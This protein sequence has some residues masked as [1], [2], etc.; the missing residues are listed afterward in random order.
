M[1]LLYVNFVFNINL[2]VHVL[3]GVGLELCNIVA[4]IRAKDTVVTFDKLDDKLLANEMYIKKIYSSYDHTPVTENHVQKS[5][6]P[7]VV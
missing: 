2:V 7:K 6:N 5:F 1:K 4:T 3:N